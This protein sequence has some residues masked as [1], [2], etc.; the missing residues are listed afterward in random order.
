MILSIFR[1][2]RAHRR[3]RA[4]LRR[5]DPQAWFWSPEWQAGE[6]AADAD[7]A[8]GRTVR[9]ANGEDAVAWLNEAPAARSVQNSGYAVE[10]APVAPSP[11]DGRPTK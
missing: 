9:F 3:Y 4:A 8:A 7:I 2:R 5:R 6:R 10:G 11:V 1:Q